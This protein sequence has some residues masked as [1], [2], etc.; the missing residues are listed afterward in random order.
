MRHME[1]GEVQSGRPA[2]ALP[3]LPAQQQRK[4]D[5]VN[6]LLKICVKVLSHIM[7]NGGSGTLGHPAD[8]GRP[9]FPSTCDTDYWVKDQDLQ[10]VSFP[11]CM[12]GCPAKK[13]TTLVGK[14]GPLEELFA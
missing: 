14:A 11:Q 1:Q 4:V 8:P 12:P 13:E 7:Q 10:K 2:A 5:K 9:P 6:I 3:Y